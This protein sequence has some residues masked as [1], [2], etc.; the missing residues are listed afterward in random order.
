MTR[1]RVAV[2]VPLLLAAG[3][4]HARADDDKKLLDKPLVQPRPPVGERAAPPPTSDGTTPID[5]ETERLEPAG[6]PLLAGNSDIGVEFG[7]VGTLTRFAHGQKP[8]IWNVD[9]VLALSIKD[10]PH[11]A[12]VAQQ[13]YYAQ[14]DAT[15]VFDTG[16]RSTSAAYYNRFVD[17]GW[18]GL[19]N[20]SSSTRPQIIDGN[21][22]R[23]FQ[24]ISREVRVRSFNRV[25]IGQP[26]DLMVAPIL[27][28]F[29]PD[30]YAGSKLA[31]DAATR[32]ASGRPL[33]HGLRGTG[34]G[35]LGIGLVVDTRDNE[36]FPRRGM[37]H[38]MGTRV[39]QGIPLGDVQF[40]STGFIFANYFPLPGPFVFATRIVLDFLYGAPPFYD[41]YN[42]GPFNV[43]EMPG[44]A[45]G[46]RG[47]P[48]GRYSGE[49]K[50]I[51]N[52]E[53]RLM[54]A[55]FKLLGQKFKLGN[56]GFVDTGRVWSD[57]TFAS[58]LDGR[59]LGLKWGAG[60]GTYI[61]WGE[62]A[63]FRI[64]FAYSPDAVAENRNFPFGLYVA[65]S[66]MF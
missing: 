10:G 11:G 33:L 38:Q 19:G 14:L 64:D 63:V 37:Y 36:F 27:R 26:F 20:A 62:A 31:Q 18:F 42:A 29:D 44:G 34:I 35:S 25:P 24:Y 1:H 65:D 54:H 51:A 58:P 6:F 2:L 23:Y 43:W 28:Y 9:V 50:A 7:G 66:V 53:L 15:D 3:A 32:D 59:G 41:L 12:E 30:T 39:G 61:Q 57:Y 55:R 22:A 45:E 13:N 49:V 46:V 16:V 52:A 8:Y 47:V 56:A 40:G 5:Y 4:S 21:R 17:T 48:L 60:L